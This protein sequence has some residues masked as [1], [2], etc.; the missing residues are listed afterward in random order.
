M[1]GAITSEIEVTHISKH[2]FWL[3]ARGEEFFLSF[4]DFPWFKDAPVKHILNVEEPSLGH[5]YWPA[6]D[7]DLSLEIIRNPSRFPLK[8]RTAR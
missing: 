1:P 2:G 7:V 8:S 6:L 4:E 5:Y 3:L